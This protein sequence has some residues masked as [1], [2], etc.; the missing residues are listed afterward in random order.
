M[1]PVTF[2]INGLEWKVS[3][4]LNEDEQCFTLKVNNVPFA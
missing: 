3:I 1:Y 4:D 2:V